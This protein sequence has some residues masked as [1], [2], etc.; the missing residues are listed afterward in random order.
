MGGGSSQGV[1][2]LAAGMTVTVEG[3]TITVAVDSLGR[4]ELKGV[5]PGDVRLRFTANGISA[6]L[7]LTGVGDQQRI[8]ITVTI[9]GTSVALNTHFRTT[10][11]NRI[12]LEG[13]ITAID[14]VARTIQVE[15]K[16]VTVTPDTMIRHGSMVVQFSDLK[17]GDR[18]HVKGTV[19]GTTITALIVE[20]QQMDG[21]PPQQGTVDVEGVV[22]ALAGSCPTLTFKLGT[23]I[24]KTTAQTTFTTGPCSAI[25]MG[26]QVETEGLKQAD[27]T[28]T[29]LRVKLEPV[30][31]EGVVSAVTTGC[32]S[33]AFSVG[34]TKITSSGL[35]TYSG[36]TCADI[37]VGA[38]IAAKGFT[39]SDGSL[40]ALGIRILKTGDH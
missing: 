7:T 39:Q 28:V 1:R 9:A 8:E 5:P 25:I 21:G 17:V 10:A 29:A 38:K 13:R 20:A 15:G 27:G 6:T 2:P 23:T 30:E 24:V 14:A 3:T 22:S 26:S 35:T 12:E 11:D 32:P 34:G 37:K 16:T 19:A 4:F 40:A 31:I 18:V 33:P 36:G